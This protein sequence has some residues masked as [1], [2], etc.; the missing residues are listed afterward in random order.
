MYHFFAKS[1]DV[2]DLSHVPRRMP[3]GGDISHAYQRLIKPAKIGQIGR[4]LSER[5]AFFPNSIILAT[6]EKVRW[7]KDGG[8]LLDANSEHGKLTIPNKYGCLFVID[9]QHRLFGTEGA[10]AEVRQKKPLSICLIEG[11]EPTNQAQMFTSINQTQSKVDPDLLWDLYGELGSVNPPPD[12]DVRRE[13]NMATQYV[14]SNVWKRVNH[15]NNHPMSG[16]IKIPSHPTTSH[17]KISFGNTLC[18]YL[19]NRKGIWDAGFL[20][21]KNGS[22]PSTE[23]FAYARVSYFYRSLFTELSE[24]WGKDDKNWLRSNYSL[25]VITVV[26]THM[27]EMFGGTPRFKDDWNTDKFRNQIDEFAKVM[28]D[29]IQ[30]PDAGFQN[31][32]D[33]RNILKAGSASA[34][35]DYARELVYYIRSNGPKGYS[36]FAPNIIEDDDKVAPSNKTKK[37]VET[38]ERRF[39]A[40]IFRVLNDKYG[41]KWFGRLPKDVK[42][43]IQF[44]IDEAEILGKEFEDP[45]TIEY[46]DL[47]DLNHLVKIMSSV[48]TTKVQFFKSKNDESF[49]IRKK[50]GDFQKEWK[51]FSALRNLIGHHN[52]YPSENA[53]EGMLFH[54]GLMETYIRIAEGKLAEEE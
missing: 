27:V 18:K 13:V 35:S 51:F 44:R 22:W 47:T 12:P 41:T 24:E 43:D 37:R 21:P 42:A 38:V 33:K 7:S 46:M 30:S 32:S 36:E 15:S 28:A 50:E 34:R 31:T 8:D 52:E 16:T 20:R 14:I 19:F 25:I 45:P 49:F 6:E 4:H 1:G 48:N 3:T 17:S 29:A 10:S 2:V 54:L 9:G 39:R 26:F 40:L 11:L 5:G 23:N 53:K